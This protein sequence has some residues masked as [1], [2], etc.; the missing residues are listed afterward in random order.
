MAVGSSG[1]GDPLESHGAR[2]PKL[3]WIPVWPTRSI[4]LP[5]KIA[6]V[7]ISL[8]FAIAAVLWTVGGAVSGIRDGHLIAM[9]GALGAAL[10]FGGVAFA[11]FRG[12]G[13]VDSAMRPECRRYL[14]PKYGAGIVLHPR[15]TNPV[16]FWSLGGAGVY[17]IMAWGDWRNRGGASGLLPLSKNN[18]GGATVALGFGI[19]AVICVLM[20]AVVLR[21]KIRVELY[22]AGVRRSSAL[23][24]AKEDLFVEW[25]EISSVAGGEFRSSPQSRPL[26]TV[27]LMVKE[28]RHPVHRLERRLDRADRFAVPAYAVEL[29]SNTLLAAIRMLVSRPEVRSLLAEGDAAGWLTPPARSEQRR[30]SSGVR[31]G[32]WER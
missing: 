32:E 23:P 28:Q 17:G 9:V 11:V 3:E 1:G 6:G 22:P 10:L 24:G 20:L 21:W 29:D 18:P 5:S 13:L 7:G 4:S 19:L 26:P 14:D 25:D 15:R 8:V 2:L 31:Q 27:D 30:L 12:A 16:L